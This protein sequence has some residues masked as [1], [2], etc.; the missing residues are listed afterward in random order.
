[1]KNYR[2]NS[3][4]NTKEMFDDAMSVLVLRNKGKRDS[5]IKSLLNFDDSK[6][7][8]TLKSP[9][10]EIASL[11]FNE[12]IIIKTKS[13][14]KG[15]N[16]KGGKPILTMRTEIMAQN[17]E[18]YSPDGGFALLKDNCKVSKALL[19]KLN[20]SNN[21]KKICLPAQIILEPSYINNGSSNTIEF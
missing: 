15:F 6:L 9:Q 13:N 17:G 1:M 14:P 5:E 4:R 2:N 10:F 18:W 12:E 19:T 16:K 8:S 11:I 21:P 7:I 3:R 20:K